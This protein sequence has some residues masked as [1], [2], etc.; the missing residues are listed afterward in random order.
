M[1]RGEQETTVTW[2]NEGEVAYIYSTVPKHLRK[3]RARE[4][5]LE[6]S[7]GADWGEFVVPRAAFDPLTGFKRKSRPM[8]S[9]ERYAAAARL[10]K[11][12]QTKEEG[13]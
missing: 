6:T 4:G 3:L 12:R 8:T 5:V 7:G 9:E 1:N 10:A 13:K 2:P 11:A